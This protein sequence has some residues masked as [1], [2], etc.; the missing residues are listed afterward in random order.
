MKEEEEEKEDD[1][2]DE[3][4]VHVPCMCLDK[5][6]GRLQTK[7]ERIGGTG[8]GRRGGEAMRKAKI[9]MECPPKPLLGPFGALQGPF[10][11]ASWAPSGTF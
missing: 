7:A 5:G 8:E 1:D 3:E 6:K 10:L 2:D 4:P 11:G 9:E